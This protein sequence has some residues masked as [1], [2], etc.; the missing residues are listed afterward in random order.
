MYDPGPYLARCGPY[1]AVVTYGVD[2]SDYF[3]YDAA[4]KLV[5]HRGDG[6]PGGAF[7][8]S[9]DCSF[10]PSSVPVDCTPLEGECQVDAGA[11]GSGG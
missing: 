4:G 3:L 9:F 11:G 8:E 10:V 6:P 1:D 7:H 5:G 2:T